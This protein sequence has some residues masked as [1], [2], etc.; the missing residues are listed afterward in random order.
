MANFFA[1]PSV[2]LALFLFF[3]LFFFLSFPKYHLCRVRTSIRL[4]PPALFSS[5]PSSVRVF[6][7]QV[8][9]RDTADH[10]SGTGCLQKSAAFPSPHRALSPFLIGRFIFEFICSLP[11]CTCFG[12][13]P[14]VDI[15]V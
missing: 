2:L 13:I 4:G 8:T 7:R 12:R 15:N 14:A 10:K 1:T 9:G 6:F 5:F 3:Y 11:N